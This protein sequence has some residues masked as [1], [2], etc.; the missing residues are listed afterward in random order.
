MSQVNNEKATNEMP[1][2]DNQIGHV[3]AVMS[4]KG[5][6]GKSSITGLLATSLAKEGYKVGV[7]DADITGPSIPKLFGVKEKPEMSPAGPLPPKT[8]TGINVM[9]F[10]LLLPNEDDPVIWR[11][12]LIGGAIKQF[13]EDIYWGELDYLVVDLPPPEQVT[14][15]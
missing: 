11:G 8:V 1:K 10:N 6:V 5:G 13:W 12:P 4:G 7:M 15:R 9:S 3:V 2:P 14:L